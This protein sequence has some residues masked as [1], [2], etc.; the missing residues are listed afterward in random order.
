VIICLCEALSDRDIRQVIDKGHRTVRGVAE[1][2]GAGAS[3]GSCTCDIRRMV[4]EQPEDPTP[5][6]PPTHMV[7]SR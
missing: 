5:G 3:C 2:C 4:H 7:L 6:A 1:A